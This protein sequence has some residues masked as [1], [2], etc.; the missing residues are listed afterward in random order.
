MLVF[1]LLQNGGLQVTGGPKSF[2]VFGEGDA[3]TEVTFVA[4]PEEE[5]ANGRV[6]W[7]GEY[8]FDGLAVKGLGQEEGQKVSYRMEANG[9]KLAF[10]APQLQ[11]WS[12]GEIGQL[13]DIDV[14]V[15]PAEDAKKVQKMVEEVDPRVVMLVPPAGKKVGADILKA[16][17]AEDA[18]TVKEFKLKGALPSEGR[19]VV[20][21]G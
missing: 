2:A 3:K 12:D 10:I 6:S 4:A 11:E 13:G 1:S 21:F 18:D 14:L 19:E 9:V 5:L 8:D 7:P 20:V 16:C 17:G 15:L